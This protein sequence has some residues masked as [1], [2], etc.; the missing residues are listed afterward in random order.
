MFR[1]LLI[2]LLGRDPLAYHKGR[3]VAW[4][5]LRDN[6][7]TASHVIFNSSKGQCIDFD[8]GVFDALAEYVELSKRCPDH[9]DGQHRFDELGYCYG[10]TCTTM[11]HQAAKVAGK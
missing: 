11:E 6:P 3:Q 2:K 10:I 1:K 8:C 4:A 9:S 5:A 7:D